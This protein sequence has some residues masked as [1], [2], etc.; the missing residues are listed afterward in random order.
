VDLAIGTV[1]A[2]KYRVDRLLGEGGMGVVVAATHVAL[3]QPIALKLLRPEAATNPALVERFEREARAAARVHGEHVARVIDVGKLDGGLPYIVMEYL[4]GEDLE[5]VLS[6]RGALPVVD[7]CDYVLQACEAI[8]EAHAA[9][10]VHRDLKPA[11]MFLAKRGDGDSIVKVL[12]FGISKLL[13]PEADAIT[14]TS[15]PMGTAYYMSPEQLTSSKKVD[16]RTDIWALGVI[17]YELLTGKR[18]FDAGSMPEVVA[19]ILENQPTPLRELRPDCPAELEAIVKRCL[20]RADD[21]VPTV[22]DLAPTLARF[23]PAERAGLVPRIAKLVTGRSVPPA[24]VI[25][26]TRIEIDEEAHS[27]S[28]THVMSD[29]IDI[30]PPTERAP[31]APT[32]EAPTTEPKTEP[33]EPAPARTQAL[34]KES[35][36]VTVEPVTVQQEPAPARTRSRALFYVPAGCTL[37]CLAAFAI[38][39]VVQPADPP[40][41][42]VA[43]ST[44]TPPVDSQTPTQQQTQTQQPTQT[45]T[46]TPSQTQTPTPTTQAPPVP[47]PQT[48]T[49]GTKPKSPPSASASPPPSAPTANPLDVKL[50]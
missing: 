17:I 19:L 46:Q 28:A 24:P 11:N 6:R 4:E 26:T 39:K 5:H 10:I 37:L 40:A 16:T 41:H 15:S 45:P 49:P 48:P 50:K 7:V 29:L 33:I 36:A 18:P 42:G 47:R 20:R 38:T 44:A 3:K 1:L 43:Q 35:S 12:D 25:T 30:M 32:S 31:D 27:K 14:K 13:E 21:R 34:T 9:S 23:A 8:A 22:A 2:G